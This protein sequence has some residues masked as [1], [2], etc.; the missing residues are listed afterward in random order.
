VGLLFAG[1]Q[2]SLESMIRS[3]KLT[4]LH[5]LL[6]KSHKFS[7][8]AAQLWSQVNAIIGRQSTTRLPSVGGNLSLDKIN[9]FF[10]SVAIT[11]PGT[12]L[13]TLLFRRLHLFQL[14][15]NFVRLLFQMC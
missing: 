6:Q 1:K 8:M 9:G 2:N 13:L 12:D 3:A 10:R 5:E 7:H 15:F 11:H 4:H 14:D